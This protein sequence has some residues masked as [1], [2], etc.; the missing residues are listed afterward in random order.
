MIKNYLL[1][2]FM[3]GILN[4]IAAQSSIEIEGHVLDSSSLESIKGAEIGFLHQS[5]QAI[6]DNDGNFIL[7][8]HIGDTLVISHVSYQS[9]FVPIQTSNDILTIRLV[10]VRSTLEDVTIN[11]GYQRLKPNETNGSFVTISNKQLNEQT[12]R[13]ILDRLNGITSGLLFNVGKNNNNP[14]SET[15]ITIR[16]L[17]S[18]DGPLDPLIVVDNF[19]YEGDINNINPNDVESITVLKDAAAAS[20]WGARAGNGVIVITTKKAH[21]NQKLQVD[22]NANVIVKGKPDLYYRAQ[23]TP[24]EY[25]DYQQVLFSKG[26]Y[27]NQFNSFRHPVVPPAIQ[28]FQDAVDGLITPADSAELIN[29]MKRNDNRDQFTRYYFQKGVTQQYALNLR[30]GSQQVSWLFSGTYDKDVDNLKATYK[31]INLR[32][33]NSYRPF[34]KLTIDAGVY[35]TNSKSRS[36]LPSYNDLTTMNLS[37]QIPYLELVGQSGQSIAVPHDYNVNYIDTAGDGKLLD[38]RFYPLEEYKHHYNTINIEEI[39][40]HISAH[41]QIVDGL[42]ASL[43]YQ[44]QKQQTKQVGISD[45]SSFY[46]RDIINTFSQV[47]PITG[48]VSYGVPLGGRLDKGYVNLNSYNF[49]GQLDFDRHINKHHIIALAGTEIRDRWSSSTQA[50][51]YGYN[52]DP[53]TYTTNLDFYDYFPT[54]FGGSSTIPNANTLGPVLE[55]RFI[56]LYGNA[57]YIYDDRYTI[58]GSVRKDGSNIFGANTNNK[59][60]PLWSTGLGWEMSNER[61]YHLDWLPFLKLSVTYGVSGNVD[62]TKTALPVGITRVYATTGLRYISINQLNNPELRWEKSYQSN[63]RADFASKNRLISGSIEYYHKK[64]EDLY[65]PTPYD[66]TTFGKGTTITANAADMS[67][68]GVDIV[69][70]SKIINRD[71]KWSASFLFNYNTSKT[72]K[73]YSKWATNLSAFIGSGNTINPMPGKPLYAIAAYKWG[74]LDKEGNPQGYLN[75][76]LS[77]DYLAIRQSSQKEGL[78]G[79]S[80]VYVGPTSPTVYG[81]LLNSL[82]YKGFVLSLNFVYKF[83][84]YFLKPSLGYA[85]MALSAMD[86]GDYARRW[87]R[88]GDEKSTNVPSFVYPLNSNR[89]AFYAHSEVN[90]LKADHIRLQFINLSYS[91]LNGSSGFPFKNLQLY[92]NAANL[93]VI[94]RAN[95]YDIDPDYV[96]VIPPPATY[97]IGIKA[98][99]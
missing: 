18:I 9:Q 51:Y 25:I 44:Y 58:S 99:F 67:G 97:T 91:F 7:V 87:Q 84:Y 47:D 21:F 8:G 65:A 5:R 6:S 24:D 50:S 66:Y 26:Y 71:V 95:K 70:N 90:V 28:V 60:K 61:F 86:G 94:W 63:F 54:F 69:L 76:G 29:A 85:G 34:K 83:G 40:A 89:D 75:G 35:Y 46:M 31:K 13:N 41:Y 62:L 15:G 11:T 10:P 82:N 81:S 68:K 37:T 22:F 42:N 72:I 19:V 73:Y 14:Q 2:C 78:E 56:S 64:G 92:A 53:Q 49:R 1:T 59:W 88:P 23:L 36:G 43:M 17:S 45:I 79:G 32:F 52:A 55:N 48:V 80:F 39:L 57:S 33:E 74:G 20:I 93:G 4:L 38:W 12:G 30:G 98:G 96:N 77:E 27:D 3:L 16:G